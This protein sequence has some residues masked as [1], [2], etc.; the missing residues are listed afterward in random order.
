MHESQQ[1]RG[2][3]SALD[4]V[5]LDERRLRSAALVPVPR[6]GSDGAGLEGLEERDVHPPGCR[7]EAGTC[8]GGGQNAHLSAA[9]L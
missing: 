1:V 8:W 3:N 4:L 7:E 6:R 9:Q 2:Q 5:P